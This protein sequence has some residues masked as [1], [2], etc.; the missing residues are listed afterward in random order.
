MFLMDFLT[1]TSRKDT[2]IAAL[3]TDPDWLLG[4]HKTYSAMPHVNMHVYSYPKDKAKFLGSCNKYDIL[5]VDHV[6]GGDNGANIVIQL[7]EEGFMGKTVILSDKYNKEYSGFSYYKNK[8]DILTNPQTI[9]ELNGTSVD[10]AVEAVFLLNTIV[11][12]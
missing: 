5:M 12:G 3:D 7:F 6:L 9:L 2:N 10:Q 4:V 1:G 11:R 8:Q